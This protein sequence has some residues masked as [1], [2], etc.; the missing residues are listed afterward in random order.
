M[1]AMPKSEAE[2]PRLP[3]LLIGNGAVQIEGITG[4]GASRATL[5]LRLD[6]TR[7][8]TENVTREGLV[9]F[10]LGLLDLSEQM[11]DDRAYLTSDTVRDGRG[12][13]STRHGDGLKRFYRLQDRLPILQLAQRV[14]ETADDGTANTLLTL[15]AN[16]EATGQLPIRVQVDYK[17]APA[18]APAP[19]LSLV[20]TE[21]PPAP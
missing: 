20:R 12:A 7:V 10:A 8:A 6:G 19:V 5:T 3:I 17:P 13:V 14:V 21:D 11:V 2:A 9:A 4:H 16:V 18:P 15:L 1:T